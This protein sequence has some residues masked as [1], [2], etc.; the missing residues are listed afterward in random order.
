MNL[1]ASG[2][3]TMYPL[4]LCSIIAIAVIFERCIYW[5]VLSTRSKVQSLPQSFDQISTLSLDDYKDRKD[6]IMRV[7]AA[8]LMQEEN[9]CNNLVKLE[10]SSIQESMTRFMK[11][12]DTLISVA[13]MLGILGT[14]IGMIISFNMVGG[15]S[16]IDPNVAMTGVAQ[17]FITTGAG[18]VIS[19]FCLIAHNVF[20]AK[21][22]NVQV[23]MRKT[24]LRLEDVSDA[25]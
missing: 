8:F 5:L 10:I 22:S 21:M 7:V 3:I 14:V 16:S 17:A 12:L 25:K 23:A 19:I 18:L 2:G 11:I 1:I 9:H 24:L 6:P 4:I 13:P 15:S 20:A